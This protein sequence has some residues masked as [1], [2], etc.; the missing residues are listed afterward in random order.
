MVGQLIIVDHQ[1]GILQNQ[2]GQ[3]D[4]ITL[5]VLTTRRSAQMTTHNFISQIVMHKGAVDI[6]Q[7]FLEVRQ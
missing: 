5:T 4:Q 3:F 1:A 2:N 6:L 7:Q